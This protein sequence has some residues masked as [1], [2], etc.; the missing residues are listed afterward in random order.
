[1]T[2]DQ[3][4]VFLFFAAGFTLYHTLN[5]SL[6]SASHSTWKKISIFTWPCAYVIP[7][8]QNHL[9]YTGGVL[10]DIYHVQQMDNVD[11]ISV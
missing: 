5:L 1:M 2:S 7:W 8:L 6:T 4:A 11:V 3:W 9:N 10:H